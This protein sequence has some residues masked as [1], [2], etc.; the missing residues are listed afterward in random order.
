MHRK[1]TGANMLH[2]VCLGVLYL[3]KGCPIPVAAL[4]G[5]QD[6]GMLPARGVVQVYSIAC[7]NPLTPCRL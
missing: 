4:D 2:R 7:L 6:R 5:V 3:L 1:P